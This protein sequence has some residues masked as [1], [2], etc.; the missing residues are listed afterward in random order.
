MV[1]HYLLTLQLQNDGPPISEQ[2]GGIFDSMVQEMTVVWLA[3]IYC[4][5]YLKVAP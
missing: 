4:A 2:L 5:L 3:M 1:I